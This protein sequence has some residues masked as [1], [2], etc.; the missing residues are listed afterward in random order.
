MFA[1][2]GPLVEPSQIP[3]EFCLTPFQNQMLY[4]YRGWVGQS[5]MV[6]VVIG[7]KRGALLLLYLPLPLGKSPSNFL[8]A[9]RIASLATRS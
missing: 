4:K 7:Q 9:I 6:G 2:A 5:A 3:S 8:S 1:R